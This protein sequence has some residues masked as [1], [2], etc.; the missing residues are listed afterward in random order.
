LKNVNGGYDMTK[1]EIVNKISETISQPKN[2][3]EKVIDEFV[4][5]SQ[6]TLKAGEKVSLT[7]LGSFI[8]KEKAAR[9][10]RNPKTGASVQVPAKKVVKFKPG[11]ELIEV[12]KDSMIQ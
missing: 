12:L 4:R 8:C 1:L 6:D 2:D 10:A 7:G 9:T 3:I 11:K 5:I